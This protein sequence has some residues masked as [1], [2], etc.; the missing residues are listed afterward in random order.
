ML[1][2]D[3]AAATLKNVAAFLEDEVAPT[4]R[5][6]ITLVTLEENAISALC[7]QLICREGGKNQSETLDD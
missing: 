2:E 4:A 6:S 5:E 3:V 1:E 7:C